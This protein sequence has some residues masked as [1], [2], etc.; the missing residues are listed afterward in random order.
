MTYKDPSIKFLTSKLQNKKSIYFRLAPVW[1]HGTKAYWQLEKI[2]WHSFSKRNLVHMLKH[3][4]E[5]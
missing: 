5:M 3:P 2:L 4:F 1:S